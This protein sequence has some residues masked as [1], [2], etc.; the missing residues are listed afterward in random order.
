[1]ADI[2][3]A[4]YR[5]D[6][7][8]GKR[9]PTG[10][11]GTG[12][13]WLARWSDGGRQRKKSFDK[14]GDA[15]RFL[16][17]VQ[18]DQSRGL[19]V[20]PALGRTTVT[21]YAERWRGEQLHRDTTADRLERV[22]RLHV[23][24]VLGHLPLAQ[25]RSGHVQAWVKAKSAELS[26]ST[27]RVTY[28][29][30]AQMFHRAAVDRP[31][32]VS[33][34]TGIRLPDVDR[35]DLVIPTPEQVHALAEALPAH[36]AAVPYVAAATGLRGGE[37]FGLELGAVDFL[38]RVLDVRQQ[39]QVLAG[40]KPYLAQVKT[41]TSRRVVELPET[42]ALALAR[43]LERFGGEVELDDETDQR[44][45]ARRTAR[46]VFTNAIG[47]AVHRASWSHVWAP[48][49]A[50]AGLPA[51]FGLHGL[52]DFYAT[53]LIHAGASV[54]TVQGALGHATPTITL[55]TY[56]GE[57]PEAVDRTRAILDAALGV[58]RICHDG[59]AAE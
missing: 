34:C 9:V 14:K 24:P 13:R 39:L 53:S 37:L 22:F 57:W 25:V 33:P 44:R 4:W 8:T 1:M 51:R 28:S 12:K 58:P 38:R 2:D 41:K 42:A 16:V 48:A 21:E 6:K 31:I 17:Q 52:R 32:G 11:H 23:D 50:A 26:P 3:D 10:R 59:Q 43:H 19:Y 15:E 27:L 46:L 36:Y 30:L 49:V 40:R 35:H 54:K 47:G 7:A 56:V 5:L 18:A 20:D 29:N 55:N 45:P